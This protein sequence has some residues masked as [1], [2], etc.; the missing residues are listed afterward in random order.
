[1]TT[2]YISTK[3]ELFHAIAKGANSDMG[4]TKTDQKSEFW[5]FYDIEEEEMAELRKFIDPEMDLKP[6]EGIDDLFSKLNHI[7]E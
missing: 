4:D 5:L 3:H 2:E 7:L 6:L 1:M